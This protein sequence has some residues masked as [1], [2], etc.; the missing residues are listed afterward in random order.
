M[1]PQDVQS[2]VDINFLSS[3]SDAYLYGRVDIPIGKAAQL[4]SAKK[5]LDA[6][7]QVL[8]L[9]DIGQGSK[10]L[11]ASLELKPELKATSRILGRA[12]GALRRL[13]ADNSIMKAVLQPAFH[14]EFDIRP[15]DNGRNLSRRPMEYCRQRA[16]AVASCEE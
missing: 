2:L 12:F 8:A 7:S 11:R 10:P 15:A 9:T 5:V 6:V 4:G 13:G 3:Y 16:C 1:L 14:Q